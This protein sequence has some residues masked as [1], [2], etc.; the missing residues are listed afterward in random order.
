MKPNYL[1]EC[2]ENKKY[3]RDTYC[4]QYNRCSDHLGRSHRIAVVPP[5][6][7]ETPVTPEDKIQPIV[8]DVLQETDSL[9]DRTLVAY[10]RNINQQPPYWGKYIAGY[11]EAKEKRY[12]EAIEILQRRLQTAPN[13]LESLYTLAWT[14]AKRG[15]LTQA[16][17]ITNQCLQIDPKFARAALLKGW[18]KL[19]Q[20]EPE[21]AMAVC[22][23][24]MQD[25]PEAPGPYYGM[26]RLYALSGDYDQAIASYTEAARLKPDAAE[27]YLHLGLVYERAN[28]VTK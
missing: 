12:T 20:E 24:A 25:N 22:Q 13:D 5:V 28:Q 2:H 8:E 26:G 3:C 14:Y 1:G 18:V 11:T 21:A 10:K 27:V 15:D 7:P 17:Q 16:E 6:Q 23:Q 9:Y 19:Q 4:D